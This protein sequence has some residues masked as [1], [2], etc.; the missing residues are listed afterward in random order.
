MPNQP[1]ILF[2]AFEQS[3]DQHAA[4]VI[5]QIRKR[6]PGIPIFALGGPEMEAAGAEIIETTTEHG[7]MVLSALG[8]IQAHRAR[9]KRLNAWLDDHPV[10]I[11]VPTDSP[12]ANWSICK[13]VKRRY[14][15][16]EGGVGAKTVHLV[17]PQVWAWASWRVRRLVRWS[18]LVLCLLPFEPEWFEK[19]GVKARYIGHPLFD[20]ALDS[21]QLQNIASQYPDKHP[22]IALLPGSRGPEV[23]KNWP[24][25]LEVFN[26]IKAQ[27]P[28]AHAIIAAANE[29]AVNIVSEFSPMLPDGI[30]M[31]RNQTEAV[32]HWADAVLAVSG[33]ASLHI[34][35]HA[36]PMAIVYGLSPITWNLLGRFVI[37]TRT[38]SLPNLIAKG[39]PDGAKNSAILKEFVPFLGGPG[40]VAPIV[41]EI[42]SLL[43]DADK[44]D[45]QIR[46]LRKVNEHF[47]D[48]N[49]GLEAADAILALLN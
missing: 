34:S 16:G 46:A 14:P 37:N 27:M 41:D 5:A 13:L 32:L 49:A 3:G 33:T 29:K 23:T 10:A 36:K 42:S 38:F 43:S 39:G 15:S 35:R 11:H 7:V 4:P 17:A 22:R 18:D 31:V 26:R 24:L 20:E 8:Q 28:D 21:D 40:R 44:R 45:A 47:Q 19:R 25:M 30:Q 1:C 2:T 48:H 12:A 6:K 9:L